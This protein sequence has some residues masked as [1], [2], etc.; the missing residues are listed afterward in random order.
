VRLLPGDSTAHDLRLDI[1]ERYDV[2][3]ATTD[4]NGRYDFFEVMPAAFYV[5]EAARE[6]HAAARSQRTDLEAGRVL[7]LPD[8]VLQE[9]GV[10]RGRVLAADGDPVADARVACSWRVN[11]LLRVVI[12]D[13]DALPSIEREVRTDAGGR[14]VLEDLGE[15]TKTVLVKAPSGAAGVLL[16]VP[17]VA[18][19]TREAPDIVLP[20]DGRIGGVVEW[21]DGTP[22][23]GARV[24][25]AIPR[26][27]PLRETATDE[28][29][30]FLL[31][32]LPGD[33]QAVGVIALGRTFRILMDRRVGDDDVRIVLPV[34]GALHGQVFASASK[35]P[36]SRFAVRPERLQWE[37]PF[38]YHSVGR[39]FREVLGATSFHA[40]DG[41]FSFDALEP[42][43]YRI[44]VEAEG[45]GPT[46]V[47][48]T[49]RSRERTGPIVVVL[50]EGVIATGR[51]L[52]FDGRPAAQARVSLVSPIGLRASA[53]ETA[54][55]EP[56]DA[57]TDEAGTF[58]VSVARAGA[59]TLVVILG[60]AQPVEIPVTLEPGTTEIP[61]LRMPPVA[62]IRGRVIEE[63]G[64][65]AAGLFVLVVTEAGSYRVVH[66][67]DEGRFEVEG[68]EEGRV[69]VS[70]STKRLRDAFRAGRSTTMK[71]HYA[72][73]REHWDE[74]VLMADRPLVVE[75]TIPRRVDVRGRVR[76]GD[77]PVPSGFE[78]H[79][80]EPGGSHV[81]WIEATHGEFRTRLEP[82]TYTFL[83]HLADP[84]SVENGIVD[85]S[86]MS[87][88]EILVPQVREHAVEITLP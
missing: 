23:V 40:A 86:A 73:L 6:P 74:H 9:G 27:P 11:N 60:D 56:P 82:G 88:H 3:H 7:E 55:S 24:F 41:T 80:T 87:R 59:H 85:G 71:E 76:G 77:G 66:T 78:I 83:L 68:L 22:V 52:Q 50:D 65:A 5:V 32:W 79:V 43:T 21:E 70:V 62:T 45:L 33:E 75:T 10:L 61:V 30:R 13:P 15:G 26:E 38:R 46:S 63:G 49:V 39:V 29:G 72:V 16:D 58:R 42:G 18:G 37:F 8:L 64:H 14:Y 31:R 69:I 17:V 81:A 44:H 54:M 2:M 47:T 4:E 25:A 28:R 57:W 51:V 35:R 20:P 48:A 1:A 36:L 67:D 12:V 34:P 84:T 53:V 19:E